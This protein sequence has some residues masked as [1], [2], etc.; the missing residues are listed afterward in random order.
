MTEFTSTYRDVFCLGPRFG[1][2]LWKGRD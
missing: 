2:I 1:R